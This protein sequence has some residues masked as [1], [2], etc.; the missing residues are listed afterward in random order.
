M[1][2]DR[3]MLLRFIPIYTENRHPSICV[4]LVNL[5]INHPVELISIEPHIP[6]VFLSS[7]KTPVGTQKLKKGSKNLMVDG[8]GW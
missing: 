7:L 3:Q 5:F 4:G 1:V 2:A 6:L 8:S